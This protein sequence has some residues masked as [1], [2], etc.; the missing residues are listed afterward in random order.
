MTRILILAVLL[1]IGATASAQPV[2]ITDLGQL[3]RSLTL[4]VPAAIHG[5]G[6]VLATAYTARG[7]KPQPFL[8]TYWSGA[9][10][11]AEVKG[12]TAVAL[13]FYGEAL[14][15]DGVSRRG[16]FAPVPIIGNAFALDITDQGEV[17]GWLSNHPVIQADF[18]WDGQSSTTESVSTYYER[19]QMN[20]AGRTLARNGM[21]QIEVWDDRFRTN[22]LAV[23][24]S[25]NAVLDDAN[26]IAACVRG[27][28]A[29]VV[30]Y[31]FDLSVK[32]ARDIL[33]CPFADGTQCCHVSN[34]SND[35]SFVGEVVEAGG[36]YP[37]EY[38]DTHGW[39]NLNALLPAGTG[40]TLRT[41]AAINSLGVVVG[42][43]LL[44][45]KPRAYILDR[46]PEAITVL[47]PSGR[48]PNSTGLED[49][50]CESAISGAVCNVEAQTLD[51][52]TRPFAGWPITLYELKGRRWKKI[53][54]RSSDMLG[55][56]R[57]QIKK[58]ALPASYRASVPAANENHGAKVF[59]TPLTFR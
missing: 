18:Y 50:D 36:A 46:F 32:F 51:T 5:S 13:N 7:K 16:Q 54:T 39:E 56:A 31:D 48:A 2:H 42:N 19:L 30:L 35:G 45:R 29:Q 22:V 4:T 3:S 14:V 23:L 57:F 17:V 40:W 25:T 58:R 37:F 24:P 9:R 8:W 47:P 27:S 49:V 34:I 55:R 28:P 21:G 26:R 53:G 44:G 59:S 6:I 12:R 20:S 33:G 10:P 11:L 38:S 1:S 15:N 43:G 52:G 41:A